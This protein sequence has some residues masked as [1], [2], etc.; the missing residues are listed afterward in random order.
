MKILLTSITLLLAVIFSGCGDD[1]A[2]DGES[3]LVSGGS[4]SDTSVMIESIYEMVQSDANVTYQRSLELIELVDD[5]NQSLSDF[6]A[7][8]AKAQEL[9]LVY[10]KVEAVYVAE[11]LSSSM[12]D[13]PVFIETLSAGDEPRKDNLLS[14]LENILDPSNMT[15]I[16]SALYKNAYKSIT[17]LV[18]ALYGDQESASEIFAKMDARRVEAIAI[19]ANN[20]SI[21]VKKVHDFYQED[22]EFLEDSDEALTILIN[23]LTISS[24][25]LREWRVGDPGGHTAKYDGDPSAHRF[26]Y[27]ATLTT[28]DSI[29]SI[30]QAHKNSMEAGLYEVSELGNA[31][32]EADA[33]VERIEKLLATCDSFTQAI[34]LDINDTKIKDLYDD[35]YALQQ[36]YTALINALN[37]KQDIIEADGD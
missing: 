4:S 18:Y 8:R 31:T 11:K 21:Q 25:R 20:I 10:K 28:L 9:I 36:D 6:E 19:M 34:E 5:S 1:N 26:E 17:G 3:G 13:V 7:L 37:F 29:K 2:Y 12:V 32:G 23:Q 22:T 24:N 35:S 14:E 16:E 30:V 33:V 27:Y 15:P